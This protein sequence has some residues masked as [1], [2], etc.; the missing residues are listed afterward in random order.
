MSLH[1]NPGHGIASLLGEDD[2]HARHLGPSV[3]DERRMLALLG[4]TTR[5]ALVDATIPPPIRLTR[6]IDLP[7]PASEATALAE[8]RAIASK[9]QVWRSY[10][11]A[12]YHGTI[13]PEAIRRNVLEN[14]G[15]YTAY[16]P[17]QAEIAQ[18]RLEALLN[19][20]QMV[21][22]LTGLAVA[23]ASLLDEATAAAEAM[24]V[25]RR[26]SKT[27]SMRY[28]VDAGTHPQ[29]LAV[30]RTRARWIGWEVVVADAASAAAAGGFFGA[31][32]QSPDTQG[33]LHDWSAAIASLHAEG[34][35]VTL[36]C[37][38][39][40]LMLVRSPGA[41]GADIA[42]GSAQRFG[43]PMGF[44]GPH[45]AFMSARE[46]LVRMMPGRI[47]GVS[48]DAAG[49]PALRM[50]L[51]TREQHIRRDKATSNVCTA[52]ALLANMASFYAVWHGPAG[53]LR[54]ALR[55]NAM[56]RLLAA[57]V[58]PAGLKPAHA[59]WFDTLVFDLGAQLPL[60]LERAARLAISLRNLD[61]EGRSGA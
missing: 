50:A 47:I 6:T 17:Y 19:Y 37:D 31:H 18:G 51:Q 34:A 53:L 61:R 59:A 4:V 5:D 14:P 40:A 29:V 43:V 55:V 20:Q 39:L 10:I 54:I 57:L 33:R 15:W 38:P 23:N 52:Q 27:A 25:A 42:I 28:L 2:F 41:M 45:A 30:L 36:G 49:Q 24:A 11:G 16:T 26:A 12:G 44:G 9:N 60:A 46:A 3:E 35:V 22:D 7:E 21:V 48:R 1:E 13:T 58:A 56:S 8:L 32:L